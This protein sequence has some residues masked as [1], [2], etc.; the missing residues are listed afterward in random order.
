MKMLKVHTLKPSFNFHNTWFNNMTL[1]TLTASK[2]KGFTFNFKDC[3]NGGIAFNDYNFGT[4]TYATKIRPTGINIGYNAATDGFSMMRIR[5]ANLGSEWQGTGIKGIGIYML[6]I[7]GIATVTP[8]AIVTCL[9]GGSDPNSE[10]I[11]IISQQKGLGTQYKDMEYEVR[12]YN[13]EIQIRTVNCTGSATYIP[14]VGIGCFYLS[15][16]RQNIPQ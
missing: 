10:L 5:L 15:S 3:F 16:E 14:S 12:F 9:K 2:Y 7:N 4:V 1:P 6:F 11:N 13:G 8:K